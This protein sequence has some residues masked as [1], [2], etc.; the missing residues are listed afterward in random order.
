MILT[1]WG[2]KKGRKRVGQPK[3]K[4]ESVRGK[5][6]GCDAQGYTQVSIEAKCS[7]KA[8]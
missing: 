4:L 8:Y 3:W 1:F 7:D 6:R 2:D 5:K